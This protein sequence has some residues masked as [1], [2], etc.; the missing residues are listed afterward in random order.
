MG[1]SVT[2][3]TNVDPVLTVKEAAERLRVSTKT[4]RRQIAAGTIQAIK[5]LTS[6]AGWRI[7][8]SEIDRILGTKKSEPPESEDPNG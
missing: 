7:R 6:R 8:A 5:P 3:A 1:H 2:L 4:I